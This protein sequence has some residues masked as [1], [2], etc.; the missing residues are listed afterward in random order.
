MRERT[1][2]QV[3]RRPITGAG[4]TSQQPVGSWFPGRPEKITGAKCALTHLEVN[5]PKPK[6]ARP[7]STSNRGRRT[8]QERAARVGE[9]NTSEQGKTKPYPGASDRCQRAA[10]SL[11]GF[12]HLLLR[13]QQLP[14][15]LFF[16][17]LAVRSIAN[18]LI[19]L[20]SGP[21]IR[22]VALPPHLF[23]SPA[24]STANL[25]LFRVVT[26]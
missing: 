2:L 25:L 13:I 23:G 1:L 6:R 26:P 11:F 10:L 18:F 19:F 15:L 4:R 20:Q 22:R 9:E 3:A 7:G 17:I 5:N 24:R 14:S 8:T 12:D 16:P 21:L